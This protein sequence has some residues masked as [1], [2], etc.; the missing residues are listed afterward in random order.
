[1]HQIPRC[2]RCYRV[3]EVLK[4]LVP[5]VLTV[6]LV[7]SVSMAQSPVPAPA[8]GAIAGQVVDAGTGKPVSAAM[9]VSISGPAIP[10][11]DFLDQ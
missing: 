2:S 4:V 8:D 6:L 1:M 3:L 10:V 9:V 5:R 11:Q 7:L